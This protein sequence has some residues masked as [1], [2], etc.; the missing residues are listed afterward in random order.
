MSDYW[1][2]IRIDEAAGTIFDGDRRYVMMRPDVLMGMFAELPAAMRPAALEAL[3]VSARKYGGQS[4][5][6]YL[7]AVGAGRVQRAVI[8]GAAAFGWGTWR[9]VRHADAIELTVD[10]SPFAAG[11]GPSDRPVCAPV[12]G[13]FHGLAAALLERDVAVTEA[14][15]AAQHPGPCRF[16]ARLAG[17]A[18]GSIPAAAAAPRS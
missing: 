4:I 1:D 17:T 8:D 5:A 18:S 9:I 6:A 16:V 12:A 2:R 7:H 11:H 13:I 15:C 3:A 10:G 14:R